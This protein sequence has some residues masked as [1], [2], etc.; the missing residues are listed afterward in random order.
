MTR[1][2]PLATNPSEVSS[3]CRLSNVLTPAASGERQDIALL[4]AL[5]EVVFLHAAVQL[6][7]GPNHGTH[8]VHI[9][10]DAP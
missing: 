4:S 10:P 5:L 1:V 6:V 9:H 3:D 8:P 2:T 7:E